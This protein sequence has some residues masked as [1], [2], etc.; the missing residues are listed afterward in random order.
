[1]GIVKLLQSRCGNWRRVPGWGCNGMSKSCTR[2][3]DIAGD[4]DLLV[5]IREIF[6]PPESFDNVDHH[7]NVSSSGIIVIII[8]G[9]QHQ[10]VH[11][12][13]E[14]CVNFGAIIFPFKI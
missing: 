4:A 2:Q 7:G 14:L 6:E 10:H 8:D 11:I 5:E 12:K 1:M 13:N 9:K 3:S